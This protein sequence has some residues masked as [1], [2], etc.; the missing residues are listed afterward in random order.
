MSNPRTAQ[1]IP[2]VFVLSTG[3]CGS[4]MVSNLLNLHPRIL[5]LSELYAFTG[6]TAFA[7]KRRSGEWMWDLL[8]QQRNHTRVMLQGNLEEL[9]YPFDTPGA[10]GLRAPTCRPSCAPPSRI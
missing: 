3:R 6:L 8:S 5:S 9:L 4:T 10:P 1:A 7:G 2:P